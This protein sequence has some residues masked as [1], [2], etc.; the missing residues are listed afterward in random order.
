MRIRSRLRDVSEPNGRVLQIAYRRPLRIL[1]LLHLSLVLL[2]LRLAI[3]ERLLRLLDASYRAFCHILPVRQIGLLRAKGALSILKALLLALLRIGLLKQHT[4]VK[5]RAVAAAVIRASPIIQ[6]IYIS[7]DWRCLRLLPVSVD[8]NLLRII[9]RYRI[10][11]VHR[12]RERRHQ[13]RRED[14]VRVNAVGQNIRVALIAS[15]VLAHIYPLR[16]PRELK[17]IP[18]VADRPQSAAV[19]CDELASC[20]S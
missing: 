9:E 3:G 8:D 5:E 7:D 11:H 16:V 17:L 1:L 19:R 6:V 10:G 20:H 14:D 13:R 15:L 18:C 4:G 2:H 12:R